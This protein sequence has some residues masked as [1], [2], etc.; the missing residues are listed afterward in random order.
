MKGNK[1]AS[2]SNDLPY[3]KQCSLP[4][5]ILPILSQLTSCLLQSKKQLQFICVAHFSNQMLIFWYT[6]WLTFF[7][8]SILCNSAIDVNKSEIQIFT[9]RESINAICVWESPV[10]SKCLQGHCDVQ[11]LHICKNTHIWDTHRYGCRAWK[12]EGGGQ[13]LGASVVSFF[14]IQLICFRSYTGS[15]DHKSLCKI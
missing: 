13:R 1:W 8:A 14:N 6:S 15:C 12:S 7:R 9:A 4:T 2:Q 11:A 10:Y 5:A 3:K